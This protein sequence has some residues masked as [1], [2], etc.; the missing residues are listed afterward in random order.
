MKAA[1]LGNRDD[2][3][4]SLNLARIGRILVQRQMQSRTV[5]ITEIRTK[6]TTQGFFVKYDYVV[7]TFSTNGSDDA[8]NVR[9]LPWRSRS[10]EDLL[11]AHH[12]DLFSEIASVDSITVSQEIFR[13]A[14]ERKGFHDLLRG[15]LCGR[16][17]GDV[18]VDDPSTVMRKDD[19]DEQDFEP[20]RI[21]AEK[22][23]RSIAETGDCAGTV[24]HVCDGGFRCRTMYLATVAR[25]I[26]MPSFRSSLWIRGAPQS[27]FIRLMVRIRSR[28]SFETLGR[29]VRP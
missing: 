24:R 29:P 3:P 25:E 28:V 18:K 6:L 20:N 4:D 17:S 23:Y 27:M 26:L 2:S 9:T 1:N 19:E 16:M 5:V 12:L 11:D 7:E 15:P 14:V 21:H 22:V 8:L 10:A 13:C